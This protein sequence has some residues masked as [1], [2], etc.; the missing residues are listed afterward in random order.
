MKMRVNS[1]RN[2]LCINVDVREETLLII[3][4]KLGDSVGLQYAN[5]LHVPLTN[6]INFFTAVKAK[7]WWIFSSI[8]VCG[9]FAR[10]VA[11]DPS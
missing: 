2:H 3:L 10:F 5:I 6:Y 8:P 9:V 4:R 1:N 11:T 7:R